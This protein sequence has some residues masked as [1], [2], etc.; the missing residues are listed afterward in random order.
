[1]F[2]ASVMMILSSLK[3]KVKKRKKRKEKLF[4]SLFYFW[5]FRTLHYLIGSYPYVKIVRPIG[6]KIHLDTFPLSF[7]A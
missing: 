6:I 1:M 2:K 5:I 3:K 7:L 4:R